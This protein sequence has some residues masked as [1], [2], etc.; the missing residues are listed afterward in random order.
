MTLMAIAPA[1]NAR[2]RFS[3]RDGGGSP[4]RCHGTDGRDSLTNRASAQ[5]PTGVA[6]PSHSMVASDRRTLSSARATP[7]TTSGTRSTSQTQD[8]QCTPSRYSSTR[9]SPSDVWET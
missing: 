8:A 3:L 5:S 7:G 4:A 1:T 2:H 9:D 6:E